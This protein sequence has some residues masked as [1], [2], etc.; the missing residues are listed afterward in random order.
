M[1]PAPVS[2]GAA[3]RVWAKIGC[4]SFGGPAGQIALM[5]DELV[6]RRRWLDEGR[7]LHALNY[8]MLLP[9]PEAQ[10]L[11]TY[12]G[13]L[14]HRRRGGLIA[15]ALFVLPGLALVIALAAAYVTWRELGWVAG[16]LFGL[17]AAVLALVAG[18]LVRIGG[19]AL[20]RPVQQAIAVAAFAAIAIAGVPFPIVVA[21][22]A[23]VGLLVHRLAPAALPAPPPPIAAH[24]DDTVVGA[25]AAAGGLAHTRPSWRVTAATAAACLVAWLAPVAALQL[26]APE[27]LYAK[28]AVMFSGAALVTFGGAYAALAY[29]GGRAV[30]LGWLAPGQMVDAL[31]LAETTPGPLVLVLPFVA[32]VAAAAVDGLA[33]GV[34]AAALA[35]WVTFAP[36]FLWIFVGAPSIEALRGHRGAH[37]A[38]ASITAA[39]VGVIANLSLWFALHT[40]FAR[41]A[42]VEL[43]PWTVAL[44]VWSSI[45]VGAVVLAAAAMVATLRWKVHGV[46][47][48]APCAAAGLAWRL[49]A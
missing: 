13:W 12:I 1:P 40:L 44:P 8:C 48:L 32:F 20:R 5:H 29:V 22:A 25:L 27:S 2:L 18:A 36:S 33:G 41:L 39:V 46:W 26:L 28:Q 47:L 9:G 34:A 42:P 37:A 19:R 4:L 7:F 14:L 3:A 21:G 11:A 35:A 31:G 10:Q 43:G 6:V 45:D 15:G 16:L 23:A 24:D 17:K 30:A 49:V 38:L